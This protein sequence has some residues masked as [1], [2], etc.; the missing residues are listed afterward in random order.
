MVDLQSGESIA[1]FYACIL[2][3]YYYY[4]LFNI[5]NYLQFIDNWKDTNEDKISFSYTYDLQDK[6]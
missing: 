5:Q 2:F 6:T 1:N 3:I 4:S